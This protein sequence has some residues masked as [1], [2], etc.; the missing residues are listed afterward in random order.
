MTAA[1]FLAYTVIGQLDSVHNSR[2]EL[3]SEP[4]LTALPFNAS[5]FAKA[6]Y[7]WKGWMHTL[8]EK[9]DER[10]SH[11]DDKNLAWNI[12]VGW[13][14]IGGFLAGGCLVFAKAAYVV[15]LI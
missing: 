5:R 3:N 9:L 10:T 8:R 13:A 7:T 2:S 12:G 1:I 4:Q 15:F 11:M 14:C 6:R